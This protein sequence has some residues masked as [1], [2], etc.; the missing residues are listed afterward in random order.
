MDIACFIGYGYLYSCI[1]IVKLDVMKKICV[2][3][4]I[5]VDELMQE[6]LKR[7]SYM[8]VSLSP[9]GAA[10]EGWSDRWI[11][12]GDE[13]LWAR[14]RMQEACDRINGVVSAYLSETCVPPVQEDTFSFV[15]VLPDEV[16]P[17]T[18]G[19][20]KRTI[21]EAFISYVLFCWYIDH[22]PDKASYQLSQFEENLS[23]LRVRLNRRRVPIRRPVRF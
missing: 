4:V 7:T 21:R 2:H 15:L 13:L 23:L 12:T 8:A 14:D 16:F 20:V 10:T 3:V 17:G 6:L 19:V 9:D 18:D 11:L 5:G 1:E 22:I